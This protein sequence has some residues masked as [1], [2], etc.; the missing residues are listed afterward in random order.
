IRQGIKARRT[1][2]EGRVRALEAMRNERAQRRERQGTM[3]ATIQQAE[4]SGKKVIEAKHISVTFDGRCIIDDFS[5]LVLRGDRIGIVGPNGVGKSTLINTLLG[6]L[7]P[8]TG[9]V[10]IGTNVDIAYFD[11]LRAQLDEELSVRENVG[12]G[13]DTV[14]INGQNKHIMGYLQDFLFSPERAHTPVK[15]LSG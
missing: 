15:A 14:C 10:E 12:Q 7:K 4:S 5:T 11:Q 9:S 2:N 1:R 8:D 6:K 3:N 13:S